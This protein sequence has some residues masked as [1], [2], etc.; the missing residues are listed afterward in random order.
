VK[1]NVIVHVD[2]ALQSGVG[3]EETADEGTTRPLLN[4]RRVARSNRTVNL[5]TPRMKLSL[6]GELDHENVFVSHAVQYA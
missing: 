1:A 2:P 4:G 5:A 3:F 6:R